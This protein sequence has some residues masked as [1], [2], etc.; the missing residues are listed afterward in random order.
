MSVIR[1]QSRGSGPTITRIEAW[2]LA[3]PVED[4]RGAPGVLPSDPYNAASSVFTEI[5]SL[6]VRVTDS[7]GCQGWGE[8]FGHRANPATM[9]ALQSMVMPFSIGLASEPEGFSEQAARTFHPFGRGGPVAYAA[10]GIDI[11]LWDISAKRAG[12]PLNRM[13]NSNGSS[14][15]IE[16]YASLPSF[17]GDYPR[18]AAAVSELESRGFSHVKLHET[19]NGAPA[20]VAD[21]FPEIRIATDMN[22]HWEREDVP[23]L[24][25]QL[26]DLDLWF[27]EEPVYPFSDTAVLRQLREGGL[28]VAAGENFGDRNDLLRACT[29]GALDIVQPSVAKIGGISAVERIYAEAPATGVSI[30][31]HC[32]YYGPAFFATAHIIAAHPEHPQ[33]VESPYFNWSETLHRQQHCSPTVELPESPGIGFD[34]EPSDFSDRAI[35]DIDSARR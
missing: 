20:A 10:S 34:F 18:L 1:Q 8:C 7:D 21:A 23:E 5:E 35:A 14:S 30:M 11:A 28:V 13:L 15:V 27:I 29:V 12:V 9:T 33:L 16:G 26:A 4:R 22:C 32:Y 3:Y 24:V 25:R 19:S 6:V 17:S 2:R 31:P